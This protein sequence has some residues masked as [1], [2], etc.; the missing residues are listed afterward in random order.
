MLLLINVAMLLLIDTS[1]YNVTINKYY[2]YLA[3][4]SASSFATLASRSRIFFSALNKNWKKGKC[5]SAKI[6]VGSWPLACPCI[7]T[8]VVSWINLKKLSLIK[9]KNVE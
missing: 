7:Y 1:H 6:D 8:L 9:N 5:A 3:M 4:S 2:C